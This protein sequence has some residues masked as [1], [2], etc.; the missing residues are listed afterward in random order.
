MSTTRDQADASALPDSGLEIEPG[1][2]A[3]VPH[4]GSALTTTQSPQ[5]RPT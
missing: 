4:P 3:I 1:A 5:R 2:N